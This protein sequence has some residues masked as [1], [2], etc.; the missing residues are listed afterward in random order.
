MVEAKWSHQTIKNHVLQHN[1]PFS[2]PEKT[3]FTGKL[4]ADHQLLKSFC[5]TKTNN[6]VER[7]TST[8]LDQ[9]FF[10]YINKTKLLI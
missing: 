3:V 10:L 1:K 7:N 5:T 9:C 2:T 4:K 8:C 6:R